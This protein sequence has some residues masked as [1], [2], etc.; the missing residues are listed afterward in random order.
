[1]YV[2]NLGGEGEVDGAVNQ[3]LPTILAPGW[4]STRDGLALQELRAL[5][6]QFIVS[7][8]EALP[9]R[10]GSV[11][12]IITNNVPIDRRTWMGHG[13]SSVELRRVLAQG[14]IW[15]HDGTEQP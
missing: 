8:N 15:I 6:H 4:K 9:F 13:I 14:G 1:M 10:D 2:L 3:N 12:Q 11:H 5:G 7:T